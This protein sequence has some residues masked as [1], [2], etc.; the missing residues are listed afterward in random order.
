MDF[1]IRQFLDPRA[2]YDYLLRILHPGG[3]RCPRCG[4]P[5][6]HVHRRRRDPVLDYRC[7]HCKRVFNAYTGTLLQ[8]TK[9]TPTALVLILRG[10]A[11]GE[12]TAELAREL[13]CDRATL[14]GFRHRLQANARAASEAARA[15]PEDHAAEADEV[16]LNAGEKRP[17]AP[18]A[19]RP[20]A[21][22]GRAAA[23]PRQLAQ[24]PAAAGGGPGPGHPAAAPAGGAPA[25]PRADPAVRGAADAGGMH[26]IHR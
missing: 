21:A 7:R 23:R 3:L 19:A 14:L 26:H 5:E 4:G 13:G 25:L 15:S 8:G 9:R 12:S 2:C 6:L 16:F 1:P 22:A 11:K 10:V 17:P 20:A 18:P 24:R